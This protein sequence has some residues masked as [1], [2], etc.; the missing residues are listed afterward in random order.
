MLK[1]V[2]NAVKNI[3]LIIIIFI[4]SL[5]IVGAGYYS[6]NYSS[7]SFDQ[8]LYYAL[9]G[10][11]GTSKDVVKDI[12]LDNIFILLIV[13]IIISW[14]VLYNSKNKI[15]FDLK[16]RTKSLKKQLFPIKHKFIFSL[17]I[18][19]MSVIIAIKGFKIDEFIK[20][21]TQETE[22]YNKYYVQGDSSYIEFPEKKRNLIFISLEC[23]ETSVCSKEN[24]GSWDYSIIPELE[25]LALDNI[26]FSN[27]EKLG[28]A[29]QI[30]ETHYTAAA[31]VAQTAGIPLKSTS[32]TI[33]A[34]SGRYNG[35]GEYLKNA[36][37]LGDVLAEQGYNLE[38][39]MGSNSSFGA[40]KQYFK[41]NG[42]YE[43][44]DLYTAL[45]R[46]L[47]TEDEIVWWGFEDDKLFEWSKEEILNL[48]K[49]DK[50]F[51]YI[52]QTADTHFTDGYLSK[53]VESK[54]QT[55][56]ENV[57]GYSSKSVYEFVEWIKKQDFYENTTIVIIGDHLNKQESFYKNHVPDDY[58]RTIYNVIINSAVEAKNSK[59]RIFTSMD[60]YPTM[61]ASIGIKIKGDRLGIGTNLFSERK[62]LAEE[63]GIEY[64]DAEAKKKST[65][66]NTYL[67]GND[68]FESDEAKKK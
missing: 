31:L 15:V 23:V 7:E 50:P 49:E 5:L 11:Q 45:D 1:K 22:M 68:Y 39:M 26:N 16:I 66:Y 46:G 63:V 41:T 57:Y 52:L 36:Y 34:N 24:G 3:L 42:N 47:M 56:Y 13:F 55:Q 8:V 29:Y 17:V 19:L 35:T 30:A 4:S 65:F 61:L 38:V 67:L 12:I 25:Q 37:A 21:M 59:N 43:V 53:N 14:L 27:T 60:F 62:T 6:S 44:F 51:N 58:D 20:N 33:D 32:L 48:A 54:Y 9:N 28:G 64:L 2:R 10:V 40:R 18:L